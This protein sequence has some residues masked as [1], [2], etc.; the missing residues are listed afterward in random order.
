MKESLY[1]FIFIS[2]RQPFLR[3]KREEVSDKYLAIEM[4]LILI[5]GSPLEHEI[6]TR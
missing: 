3:G 5:T 1:V 4:L 6:L 2:L